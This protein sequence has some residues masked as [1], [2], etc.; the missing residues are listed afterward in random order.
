IKR[1]TGAR[2]LRAIMEEIMT[3]VMFEIPS[4]KGVKKVII[5]EEVVRNRIKPKYVYKEAV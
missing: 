4:M 1:K 2:G 5:D 3:D